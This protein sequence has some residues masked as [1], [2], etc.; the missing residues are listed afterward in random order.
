MNKLLASAF[1]GTLMSMP[2]MAQE[3][4]GTIQVNQGKQKIYK[5]IYGQFAE[6]RHPV[7][8]Q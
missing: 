2:V 5:E 1:I 6:H 4:T 3:V 8:Q 7:R